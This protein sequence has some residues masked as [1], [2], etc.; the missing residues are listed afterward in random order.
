MKFRYL[1]IVFF[2]LFPTLYLVGYVRYLSNTRSEELVF[3]IPIVDD[4]KN[5]DTI[6]LTVDLRLPLYYDFK[7]YIRNESDCITCGDQRYVFFKSPEKQ[8]ITEGDSVIIGF[9]KPKE[10]RREKDKTSLSLSTFKNLFS[11]EIHGREVSG[12]EMT[13]NYFKKRKLWNPGVES[14]NIN[15]MSN[16][17]NQI[18]CIDFNSEHKRFNENYVESCITY[19]NIYISIGLNDLT[20]DS[21][22]KQDFYKIVESIDMKINYS[23]ENEALINLF[24]NH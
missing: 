19:Q 20:L 16:N 12:D 15:Y 5:R 23:G 7:Q 6:V 9:F 11:E 22:L 8:T 10:D 2:L 3:N 18:L 24:S 1:L 13:L 14:Y 4:L 17:G 21:K